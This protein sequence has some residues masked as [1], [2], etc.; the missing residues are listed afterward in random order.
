VD[1]QF[2]IKEGKTMQ[3]PKRKKRLKKTS[4][5]LKIVMNVTKIWA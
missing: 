5:K 1:Q 4:R 2:Y 3:W